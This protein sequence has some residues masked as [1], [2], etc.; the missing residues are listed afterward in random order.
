LWRNSSLFTE[1]NKKDESPDN[2]KDESPK[3]TVEVPERYNAFLNRQK[4]SMNTLEEVC[5]YVD[6]RTKN[7]TPDEVIDELRYYVYETWHRSY[8]QEKED[9][10]FVKQRKEE[11][12]NGKEEG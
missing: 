3:E 8:V 5:E 6:I 4:E 7:M 1:N 11:I 9:K 12:A 10:E 2:K